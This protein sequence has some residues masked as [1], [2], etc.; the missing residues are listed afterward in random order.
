MISTLL[1]VI[2][3]AVSLAVLKLQKKAWS[4]QGQGWVRV[5]RSFGLSRNPPQ[6]SLLK[7]S[8]KTQTNHSTLPDLGSALC[9]L[10]NVASDSR[11]VQKGLMKG[12]VLTLLEQTTQLT[13]TNLRTRDYPDKLSEKLPRRVK[14][15]ERR[16]ALLRNNK[17]R[18]K[19][20]PFVQLQRTIPP[21]PHQ[22]NTFKSKR[23][24]I[25]RSQ[26]DLYEK[27]ILVP[28]IRVPE[29]SFLVTYHTL[30]SLYVVFSWSTL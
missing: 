16:S 1:C 11:K 25:Q 21:L 26:R 13:H 3:V 28:C 7:R 5:K 19:I 22:N 14:F 2:L 12:D 4:E 6:Q 24:L 10:R 20:L 29:Q 9:I 18:N 8:Q 17:L 23:D 15:S 30:L 27:P